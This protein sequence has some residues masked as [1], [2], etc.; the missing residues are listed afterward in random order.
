VSTEEPWPLLG[1]GTET[2]PAAEGGRCPNCTYPVAA[3]ASFCEGCGAPLL[4]TEPPPPPT[5]GRGGSAP[6]RR[7][8]VTAPAQACLQCGG[9]VDADGYCQTC[10][11]KAPTGR[12]HLESSPAPWLAG[13]CDRGVQ[14][15]RNEDAMALW[16]AADAPHGVLVVCDG[17]STS[18]EADLASQAGV[19]RACAVLSGA[20]LTPDTPDPEVAELLVRA[21]AE[22][23]SAISDATVVE[24]PHAGSAT[25]AAAVVLGDAIHYASLGDSRVY[26]LSATDQLLLTRDDS[27]A[28]DFI[29]QG[30][31]R[32]EAEAMPK[33]HAITR[34]LGSDAEDFTPR[35]GV[36]HPSGEGWLVVCSD[37]LWNYASAPEALAV[38]LAAA[39]QDD[40]SPL[41][42]ARG[43][44]VWANAQGGHDNVTVALARYPVR[45]E[46]PAETGA[47]EEGDQ[48]D[49]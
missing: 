41:A 7:L 40:P 15:P 26:W 29:D 27:V 3:W 45:L 25:F 32:D 28:Q 9:V 46:E 5:P 33:A 38:Q 48:I 1:G 35:T 21:A 19:D 17:V 20:G 43:L 14:H 6:T 2:P 47:T 36:H 16:A 34:W 11:A 39:S 44:V 18:A 10:G 8:G 31:P 23:N 49:G 4:P 12:D 13:V 24:G 37:G 30:M 42:A 22:A